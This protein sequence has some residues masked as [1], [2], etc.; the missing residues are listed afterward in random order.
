MTPSPVIGSCYTTSFLPLAFDLIQDHARSS[1]HCQDVQ[2][3]CI[4]AKTPGF[5][6]GGVGCRRVLFREAGITTVLFLDIH[7]SYTYNP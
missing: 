1:D 6:L 3:N 5:H 4:E 2:R 7:R